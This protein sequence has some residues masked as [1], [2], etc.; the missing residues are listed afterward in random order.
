[1]DEQN[2]GQ[3][4]MGQP[5]R[6]QMNDAGQDAAQPTMLDLFREMQALNARVAAVEM[7]GRGPGV[8]QQQVNQGLSH[9]GRAGPVVQGMFGSSMGGP[10]ATPF[11]PQQQQMQLGMGGGYGAAAS[12][13]PG[14]FY[15]TAP[16]LN[17]ENIDHESGMRMA[18]GTAAV[19]EIVSDQEQ[20]PERAIVAFEDVIARECG[21]FWAGQPWSTEK[22]AEQCISGLADKHKCLKR[23]L[24]ITARIYELQRHY[25][26][27]P[28]VARAFTARAYQVMTMAAAHEGQWEVG[29]GLLGLKDPLQGIKPLLTTSQ[30]VAVVAM[31]REK[32]QLAEAIQKMS[33]GASSSSGGA[34]APHK[35]GEKDSSG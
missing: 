27:N 3:Q 8:A 21:V 20:N 24:A 32:S 1:M 4:M 16:R 15:Q 23:T 7:T 2:G 12:G 26:N 31:Q 5:G 25:E 35:S 30:Q 11:Q 22:H 10:Q 6:A 9:T 29:W 17:L 14:L 18:R 33:K 34:G 19:A 28:A 13:P